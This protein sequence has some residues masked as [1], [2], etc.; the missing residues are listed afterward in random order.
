MA[1]VFLEFLLKKKFES[2][3]RYFYDGKVTGM[4]DLDGLL[5]R[6]G[7]GDTSPQQSTLLSACW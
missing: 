5:S 7:N 2:L 6:S 4:E 1:T 3:Q